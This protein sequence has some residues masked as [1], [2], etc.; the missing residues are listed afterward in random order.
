M[1]ES[2]GRRLV[3]ASH[4]AGKVREIAFL[5]RPLGFEIVSASDLG[6]PVP[7]E[8]GTTFEDNA[9][10]KARAAATATGLMALAD[11]SGLCVDA[12]DGAPGVYSAD[13]AGVPRDFDI[14]MRRVEDE[15]QRVGATAPALRGARFVTVLALA[16]PEGDICAYSGT[17]DG[18]I[19]W[20]PRGDRGFGYDPCFL[21][22]GRS[23]TFGE[24]STE[25]KQHWRPDQNMNQDEIPSHRVRA[26]ANMWTD[27]P[28]LRD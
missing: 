16:R 25:E 20:P 10:L 2:K 23:L 26:F 22:K 14:A 6:L 5:L 11:D 24:M 28:W 4:N 18:E 9:A 15:L 12:L 27:A 8:T 3:V 1:G 7:E 17:V 19:V 21:P 13:W